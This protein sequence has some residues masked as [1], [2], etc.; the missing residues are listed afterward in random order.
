MR[1]HF[2]SEQTNDDANTSATGNKTGAVV[3]PVCCPATFGEAVTA[4]QLTILPTRH[5][6][7]G[8]YK[9]G[10]SPTLPARISARV[11]VMHFLPPC[12]KREKKR[13]KENIWGKSET[14]LLIASATLTSLTTLSFPDK[15][16]NK[17]FINNM[18]R[19]PNVGQ[20]SSSLRCAET[21][22][23]PH[24]QSG[25][26]MLG[27]W[28][29]RVGALIGTVKQKIIAQNTD[30]ANVTDPSVLSSAKAADSGVLALCIREGR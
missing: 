26:A 4:F 30:H 17:F 16:Q 12:R 22:A 10:F 29:H 25:R 1:L 21:R 18:W 3:T 28:T 27:P 7:R 5:F 24:L 2:L 9:V 8:T 11:C 6:F 15:R 20:K 13:G 23:Y 19:N 14:S